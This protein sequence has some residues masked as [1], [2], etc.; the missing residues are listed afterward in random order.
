MTY[1]L[2]VITPPPYEAISLD[3]TKLYLNV[4][5][6]IIERDDEI[7]GCIAAARGWIESYTGLSLI[8][9]TLEMAF[10]QWPHCGYLEL[11]RS[12]LISIDSIKY[13]DLNGVER[14][15]ADTNYQTDLVSVPGRITL[16]Y[17]GLFPSSFRSD[18]NAWKVRFTAGHP[19]GSPNNEAGYRESVPALARLAMKIYAMGA[20]EGELDKMQRV[21]ELVAHPLRTSLL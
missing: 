19:V 7:N 12:P 5:D 18:L 15:W 3:E 17:A 8:R 2:R 21:A 14:T 20:F 1:A 4:D 11:P 10:D 6:D 16:A 13:I 9:Q